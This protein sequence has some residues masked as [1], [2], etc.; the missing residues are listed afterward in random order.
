MSAGHL[1]N[2]LS[3]PYIANSIPENGLDVVVTEN[4][5][6]QD[7]L[8][9]EAV[10]GHRSPVTRSLVIFWCTPSGP[11]N[12]QVSHCFPS[13]LSAQVLEYDPAAT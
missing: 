2:Y 8:D 3:L 10:T 7:P 13:F 11:T 9:M 5:E 6:G 1:A 12:S 4:I